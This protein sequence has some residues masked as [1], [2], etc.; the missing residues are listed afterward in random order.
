M[1]N[2]LK[3]GV[4]QTA[5][6]NVCNEMTTNVFINI[7]LSC[8]STNISN[9][10]ISLTCNPTG[11]HYTSQ[12]IYENNPACKKCLQNVVDSR[13]RY[14][15]L[16]RNLWKTQPAAVQGSIDDDYQQ[17]INEFVS[18][19]QNC[20][21][22][23]LENVSQSTVIQSTTDCQ[24]FNNVKSSIS[25]KMLAEVT[26]GLTN[27]QDLLAPLA[28]ML[29]A[30]S[31]ADVITNVSNRIT[32]CITDEVITNI[33]SQISSNQVMTFGFSGGGGAVSGQTQDSA[34]NS[35]QSYLGNTNIFANV[36]SES[37]ISV[38]QELVNEMNTIDSLGNVI[39]KSV[40]YLSKLL[41]NVV[42]QVVFAIFI[43]FI[44]LF[45]GIVL[46]IS[47][48]LIQKSLRKRQEKEA[49]AIKTAQTKA[50]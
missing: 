17:V 19:S 14:Y 3:G 33:K 5:V 4:S 29:G 38:L 23:I 43:L 8:N 26:Q 41:T 20:K 27:N 49:Q 31:T 35:I 9:Q 45:L 18:C 28:Q 24:A 47:T 36:L 37:Q 46:Y 44:V 7:A 32:A 13:L 11:P 25:Q 34:F 42:G 48:K 6:V 39:V 22:C 15:E 10:T 12:N 2:L 1:G 50:F 40:G 21:A 30:S 16:Q